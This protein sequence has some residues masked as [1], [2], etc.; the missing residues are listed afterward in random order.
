MPDRNVEWS[1]RD[2]H[3]LVHPHDLHL[4]GLVVPGLNVARGLSLFCD[5]TLLTPLTATG[6]PRLVTSNRGGSLL[7]HARDENDRTYHEVD[8]SGLGRLYC[9]TGGSN[10]LSWSLF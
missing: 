7:E 10:L 6:Q 8:A 3:V 5:T 2:T 4:M 1:L 9:L